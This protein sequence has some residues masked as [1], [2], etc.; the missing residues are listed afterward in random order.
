[1]RTRKHLSDI[2]E[3]Q[4]VDVEQVDEPELATTG[5]VALV[6]IRSMSAWRLRST[7]KSNWTQLPKWSVCGLHLAFNYGAYFITGFSKSAKEGSW[8]DRL[9]S[10]KRKMRSLWRRHSLTEKTDNNAESICD[11]FGIFSPPFRIGMKLLYHPVPFTEPPIDQTLLFSW[12][13]PVASMDKRTAVQTAQVGQ[14]PFTDEDHCCRVYEA[15]ERCFWFEKG[16]HCQLWL[17]FT[18][19]DP[20]CQCSGKMMLDLCSFGVTMDEATREHVE[21]SAEDMARIEDTKIQ[22][23]LWKRKVGEKMAGFR[24]KLYP[25]DK[26]EKGDGE[27]HF[28]DLVSNR[29]DG[30]DARPTLSQVRD[31]VYTFSAARSTYT[32]TDNNC[33]HFAAWVLAQVTGK[34][35]LNRPYYFWTPGADLDAR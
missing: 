14:A 5:S 11:Q 28:I 6:K 9:T 12:T 17:R 32:Y 4:P 27:T 34:P 16:H 23:E 22:R 35:E 13:L 33:Q 7:Q 10:A 19:P 18:A 25:E 26:E 30:F 15:T 29:S 1:M 3:G 2:A 21:I 31:F 20:S 24:V 8:R